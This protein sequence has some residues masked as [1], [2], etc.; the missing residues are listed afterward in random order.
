MLRGVDR[1]RVVV[2]VDLGRHRVAE[3]RGAAARATSM[4][5]RRLAAPAADGAGFT[6]PARAR[7]VSATAA[8][9]GC[10]D[11]PALLIGGRLL[12]AARSAQSR[13]VRAIGVGL[14]RVEQHRVEAERG[15]AGEQLARARARVARAARAP[16]AA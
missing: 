10:G 2:D 13:N 15:E 4:T 14:A 7:T 8:T 12:V 11:E 5:E 6:S 16:R 3:E 9:H 1:L